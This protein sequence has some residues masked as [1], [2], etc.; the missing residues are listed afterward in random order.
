MEYPLKIIV[1]W[2][3]AISGNREIRDW[4]IKNGYRE[5]GL[6]TYALRNKDDARDW[7][8]KNGYPHLMAL[9]NGIEGNQGALKWLEKN[10]F[11]ILRHMAL[12]GDSHEESFNWLLRNGHREFAMLAKK[13]EQ[14]KIDIDNDNSDVHKY[15]VD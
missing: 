11:N 3:E 4:L 10:N 12:A 7:L 2:G 6:F 5:L 8:M 13:M 1:A 9:I 14:V 15:K